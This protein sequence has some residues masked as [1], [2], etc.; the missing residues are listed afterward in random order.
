MATIAFI[1]LGNMGNPMAANLVKAGHRVLGF[2]LIENNREIARRNGIDVTL[3]GAQA[4]AEATVIFTM[5]ANGKQVLEIYS[6]L[7]PMAQARSLFI[8]CST[9]DVTSA[10][11]AHDIAQDYGHRSVDAPVNGNVD[12]A[13]KGA[14]TAMTGGSE[15]S[16][17]EAASILS[18][19]ANNIIHCG[20]AGCG[21]AAKIC[22]NLILGVTMLGVSEAFVLADSLGLSPQ[23]LFN[24]AS[25]SSG[26]CWSLSQHCPVAGPAP[27]APANHGYQAIFSSH[28]MLKDLKLAQQTAIETGTLT[29]LA[30]QA[31]QL[32]AMH[33]KAGNAAKDFSSIIQMLQPAKTS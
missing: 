8:D 17:L 7:A 14:L 13:A 28:L 1:G 16:V 23:A 15:A 30:T 25:N 18:A 19:F 5:L 11:N 20:E 10:R 21:Q 24:V 22:N 33:N 26:N 32:Y 6:E 4:L 12:I 3:S 27:A 2:D 31:T 9:I 29:P